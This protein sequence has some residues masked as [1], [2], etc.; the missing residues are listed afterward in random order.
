MTKNI[1]NLRITV[2]KRAPSRVGRFFTLID[3][4]RLCLARRQ[5]ALVEGVEIPSELLV[6]IR[7]L[8]AA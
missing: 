2:D 1:C 4:G 3:P 8:A 6:S 5:K 7:T